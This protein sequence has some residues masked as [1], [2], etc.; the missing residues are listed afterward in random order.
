MTPTE[1]L[2]SNREASEQIYSTNIHALV[3]LLLHIIMNVLAVM[4]EL[5]FTAILITRP[6]VLLHFRL[7]RFCSV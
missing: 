7:R 5:R 6:P 4:I 1:K 3:T 2:L